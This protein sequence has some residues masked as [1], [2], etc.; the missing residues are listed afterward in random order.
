M[1]NLIKECSFSAV[2]CVRLNFGLWDRTLSPVRVSRG[3]HIAAVR[4]GV[5]VLLLFAGPYI[6]CKLQLQLQF[7]IQF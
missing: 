4:V 6:H 5:I 7:E 3:D 1:F 2:D